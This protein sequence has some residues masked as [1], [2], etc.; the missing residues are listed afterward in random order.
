LVI[1]DKLFQGFFFY[2]I[3]PEG[4]ERIGVCAFWS[5]WELERVV[6]PE[7][8]EWIGSHA[9]NWCR[10]AVIILKKPRREFRHIGDYAFLGCKYVK[11]EIG[12]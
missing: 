11:E 7:S 8:V 6:I 2:L 4:C 5:C 9:F 1:E 12:T 3:I 10:N